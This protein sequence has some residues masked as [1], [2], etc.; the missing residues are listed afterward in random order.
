MAAAMHQVTDRAIQYL[1]A[2]HTYRVPQ[3]C[4]IAGSRN[5]I[6]QANP[7]GFL[8]TSSSWK[9]GL[10]SKHLVPDSKPVLDLSPCVKPI[11]NK[12]C[13]GAEFNERLISMGG[14]KAVH[15]GI[16]GRYEST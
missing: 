4:S 8:E 11:A 1:C 3:F 6:F 14:G 13:K 7:A 12:T 9:S 15:L 5:S 16:F 10:V 2:L